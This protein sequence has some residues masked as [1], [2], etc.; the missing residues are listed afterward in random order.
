M[1]ERQRIAA[2]RRSRLKLA[3]PYTG[4]PIGYPFESCEY[5]LGSD[6]KAGFMPTS[7]LSAAAP[8]LSAGADMKQCPIAVINA[9]IYRDERL[10]R[11]QGRENRRARHSVVLE[12]RFVVGRYH[13]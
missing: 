12:A 10:R 3:A 8:A 4:K 9:A 1:T 13:L 7:G 2:G 11:Y 5:S 6:I